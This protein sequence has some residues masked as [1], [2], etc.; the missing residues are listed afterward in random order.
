MHRQDGIVASQP[1][2]LEE[3]LAQEE[4]RTLQ[5]HDVWEWS[6]DLYPLVSKNIPEK[7]SAAMELGQWR[8]LGYGHWALGTLLG[9]GQPP[10]QPSP[11][12][13]RGDVSQRAKGMAG[14]VRDQPGGGSG[15]GKVRRTSRC[16]RASC[17]GTGPLHVALVPCV[18]RAVPCPGSGPAAHTRV[19]THTYAGVCAH[20][21]RHAGPRQDPSRGISQLPAGRGAPA[22]PPRPALTFA[23]IPQGGRG[24]GIKSEPRA[25]PASQSP[26]QVSG[27]IPGEGRAGKGTGSGPPCPPCCP[28]SCA[29]LSPQP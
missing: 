11:P 13:G 3:A 17:R 1:W 5:P 4:A 14:R 9:S 24:E 16:P 27:D 15:K 12:Q 21:H 19:H 18:P 29:L 28:A 8:V 23:Q 20:T 26:A 22:A 6:W 2:L 10:A 25:P 7:M